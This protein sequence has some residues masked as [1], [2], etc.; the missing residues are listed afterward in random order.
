MKAIELPP[1][2]A[3][4]LK[5]LDELDQTTK[6]VRLGHRAQKRLLAAESGLSAPAIG[7]LVREDEQTVGRW[8]KR[9]R[10]EGLEGLK[11]APQSG[12]PG[13]GT[14]AYEEQ[15]VSVVRQRP[16]RVDL[17]FSTWT[18]QRLADYLAEVTGLQADA[19]TVRL[20]LAKREIVLSR[21]QPKMSR[22]DPEYLVKKRRSKTPATR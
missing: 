5:A 18:V 22:P 4:Q 6:A 14:P 12:H 16:R 21:P 7:V 1:H 10:A 13:K 8:M 2:S 17:P 9:S 3:E 20:H 11:E 19:E 15:V